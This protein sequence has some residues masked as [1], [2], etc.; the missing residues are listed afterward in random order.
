M[1]GDRDVVRFVGQDKA[2]RRIALHQPPERLGVGGAAASETVRA[3]LKDV[4]YASDCDSVSLGREGA[5]LNRLARVAENDLI[6]LVGGEAKDSDWSIAKDQL[7]ELD[8]ERVEVP[9]AFFV[10]TIGGEA[11]DVLQ[12]ARSSVPS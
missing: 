8:L 7:F 10:E 4:A 3:E 5:L 12:A 9:L 2:G 1:P 11:H 6:D